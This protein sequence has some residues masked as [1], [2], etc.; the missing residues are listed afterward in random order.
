[1][2]FS[3]RRQPAI[4]ES[5]QAERDDINWSQVQQGRRNAAIAARHLASQTPE[6]RAQLEREWEG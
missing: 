6:R 1:M 4:D 2:T 3:Y 5:V